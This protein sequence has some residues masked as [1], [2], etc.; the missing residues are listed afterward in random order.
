[1]AKVTPILVEAEPPPNIVTPI[2]LQAETPPNAADRYTSYDHLVRVVKAGGVALVDGHW[3][4]QQ[5]KEQRILPCRQEAPAGA[6]VYPDALVQSKVAIFVVSYAWITRQHPD[7]KGFHLNIIAP[8]IEMF[9]KLKK[10]KRFI[11]I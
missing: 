8:M 9:M 6:Y 2:I 1:M 7:P 3:L 11:D 5:S 10:K 4:V